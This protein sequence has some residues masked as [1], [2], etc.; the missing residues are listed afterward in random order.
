MEN[1]IKLQR[2]TFDDIPVLLEVEKT[3]MGTHI[4][5]G[6]ANAQEAREELTKEIYYLIKIGDKVVGDT[7]YC[8]KEDDSAYITGLVVAKNLQRQ[9]IGRK[10]A[11]LLLEMLKDKKTIWLMTH[12]E[13]EK[14]IALYKSLGFEQVGEPI[15]NYFD[16]GEPRIKMILEK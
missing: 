2:A 10:V 11:Q 6:L 14:A 3:V 12:P 9:G 7:S 16:D 8:I 5:T 4:Y 13:N 15:K 1:E